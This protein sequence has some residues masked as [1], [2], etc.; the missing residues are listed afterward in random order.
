[1]KS[2]LHS[3]RLRFLFAS[4]LWVS[5]ATVVAGAV[6]SGL[7]RSHTTRQYRDDLAGHL[8]ELALLTAVGTDGRPALQRPMSDP[9]FRE[10]GS[11]YYW[12]IEE[13]GF[14]TVK[15]ATLG[16]A[17]L[18]GTFATS[19]Q[20]QSGWSKG[21]AG[22]A[23]E[24]G[25]LRVAPGIP[26]PLRYSIAIDRRLIDDAIQRF[27]RDLAISLTIFALLMIGGATAQITFGLRPVRRIGDDIDRLRRGTLARLPTDVPT[28]FAPLV[29]R[30][31]ALL[32]TQAAVVQRAREAAGNLAHG[33]RTPLALIGGEAEQLGTTDDGGAAEFILAQCQRMKRQIDYHMS[34]AASAGTRMTG[35]VTN[36]AEM[37]KQIVDVMRR[38][39]VDRSL[40]FMI[41]VSSDVEVSC[42]SDDL[43]EILSNLIDN[44]AKWAKTTVAIAA[45]SSDGIVA[46]EVSDDGPGIPPDQRLSVFD[47]GTRLDETKDGGGLGL[48]ISSDL[49]ALYDGSIELGSAALGGLVARLKLQPFDAS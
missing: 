29:A 36:V 1:M 7:Y 34:R 16:N 11:G 19:D 27:N 33:L 8:K 48:A 14:A 28:E 25:V 49:A 44:A 5:I 26:T 4:I 15:S 47:V 2:D 9:R 43:F 39:H 40:T 6:I 17:V 30:M 12:Q 38:L 23:L 35:S 41:D 45:V 10:I 24:L 46:I 20:T 22:E 42:D 3:L 13:P 21:P 32:D 18:K 31:N 37:V